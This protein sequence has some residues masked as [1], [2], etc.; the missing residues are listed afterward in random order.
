MKPLRIAFSRPKSKW[1]IGSWIIRLFEGAP[2]SHALLR[3]NSQSLDRDL[4]YQASHG[5]VHF[6][7]GQRF[8]ADTETVVEY[9]L[10]FADEEFTAAVQK[11]VDFAGAKYGYFTLWGIA[12][13]RFTGIKN[14]FR[15]QDKTFICSELVGDILKLRE[16][17]L[18]DV[19][20]ELAGP[21]L[22]EECVSRIPGVRKLK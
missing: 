9:E 19:D 6:V 20:L 21:K 18:I 3:W 14:P 22:L 11:C 13:E 5:S 8:D 1:S 12:L 17:S 10:D 4:I 7:S 16:G 15:D 2:F